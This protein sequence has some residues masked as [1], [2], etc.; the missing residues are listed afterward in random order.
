MSSTSATATFPGSGWRQLRN[1]SALPWRSPLF[2][3]AVV[4]GLLFVGW[5]LIQIRNHIPWV[6]AGTPDADWYLHSAQDLN[7]P[8]ADKSALYSLP[9]MWFWHTFIKPLGL[10]LWRVLHVAALLLIRDRLVV[11]A[12]LLTFPFWADVMNGNNLTF[13][14]VLAWFALRDNRAAVV[15]FAILAAVQPRPLLIPVL[16]LLLL[17]RNDARIAFVA[18][19]AVVLG[20]ALVT[21]TLDDWI[22]N[23]SAEPA[24]AM[25]QEYNKG[26]S[27]L[28][29]QAWVPIGFALAAVAWWRRWIGLSSL[30]ISP[31]LHH[32]YLMMGFLD[33]PRLRTF[34]ST[35]DRD[36]PRARAW[37]A[38]VGLVGAA[39]LAYLAFLLVR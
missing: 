17:K 34:L 29:G 15:G 18:A 23:L 31:Y 8:Y 24:Y 32:Y 4:L 11:A 16:G 27:R 25:A 30:L 6:I 12:A 5:S 19:A 35:V 26:P 33:L 20:T 36:P 9:Y 14:F 13:V 7:D 38:L 2:T 3:G 22:A 28:I 39:G 37:L 21:G 10:G 1:L